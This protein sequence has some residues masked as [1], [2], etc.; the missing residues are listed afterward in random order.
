[1][2]NSNNTNNE[3]PVYIEWTK[4]E[5]VV[6]SFTNIEDFKNSGYIQKY[7]KNFGYEHLIA[8]KL[9]RYEESTSCE[10]LNFYIT[11]ADPVHN[12]G[13]DFKI[14]SLYTIHANDG[15]D[16]ILFFQQVGFSSSITSA[17][18]RRVMTV[19]YTHL[20]LPTILLV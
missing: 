16:G 18:L 5:I 9:R 6:E 4:K 10:Y 13:L 12:Y 15:N 2:E 11:K 7:A 1:M 20:T 14:W 17:P 8:D 3:K 19:S